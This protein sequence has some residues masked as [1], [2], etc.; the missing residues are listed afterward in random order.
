MIVRARSVEQN[1]PL[2]GLANP[3]LSVDLIAEVSGKVER[4][5]RT[6]GDFVTPDDTL[7]V[8]DDLIPLSNY[9]RAQSQLQ[10]A[11]NNLQ[12][13]ELNY[14]SDEE[15]Y[16][17]GDISQ[18]ELETSRLALK[19]A[20]ANLLASRADLSLMQKTY[21]DTRIM[22]P[23]T[24]HVSRKYIDLG[25]M[26]MPNT[27]VFRIVDLS[28]LKVELGLPQSMISR[29]Q[30]GGSALVQFSALGSKKYPGDVRFISPQA[31]EGTGTFLVE[32]HVKNT[33]A[34]QIKAGMTARV[35]LV[36]KQY[37]EQ[38]VVPDYALVTK[39]GSNHVYRIQGSVAELTEVGVSAA[40]GNQVVVDRG[41][42]EGDT[43]VVVGMK[44]LGVGTK[45]YL[46]TI[47]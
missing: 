27:P 19:T 9:R 16:E 30:K 44:N 35:E 25:T 37:G 43:I 36:L 18:L 46:E 29:V 31:D 7:A 24:G 45:V 11:E 12:I 26:V 8:I 38:L 22:S 20:E 17:G 41:L 40:F 21:S 1:V 5:D 4:M 32:V 13:A 2:T 34:M 28:V 42:A 3:I 14:R 6:L 10:S 33:P 15:L 39:N 23:I 47:Q